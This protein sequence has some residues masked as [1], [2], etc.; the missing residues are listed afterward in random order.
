MV[1]KAV[2]GDQQAKPMVEYRNFM[3]ET[4]SE[5]EPLDLC[6]GYLGPIHHPPGFTER[7]RFDD[8]DL[9]YLLKGRVKVETAKHQW[10]LEAGQAF[11]FTPD[12]EYS[13]SFPQDSQFLFCHFALQDTQHRRVVTK[14]GFPSPLPWTPQRAVQ[15]QNLIHRVLRGEKLA[16]VLLKAFLAEILLELYPGIDKTPLF[17]LRSLDPKGRL[18]DYIGLNCHRVITVQDLANLFGMNPDSF[19]RFLK[20]TLGITPGKFLAEAR[21]EL[22]RQILEQG[23]KSVKETA[24]AVGYLDEFAFAKAFKRRYGQA[25]GR[26]TRELKAGH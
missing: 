10:T 15:W 20:A 12:T 23:T 9:W 4:L 22:G 24:A 25:P 8:W 16:A 11:L 3:V 13:A 1:P 14:T 2:Y 7:R 6:L 5:R 26:Y 19:A 21:M 18:L 17:P